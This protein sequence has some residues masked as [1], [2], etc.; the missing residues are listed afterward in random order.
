MSFFSYLFWC[1][2]TILRSVACNETLYIFIFRFDGFKYSSKVNC[3]VNSCVITYEALL[4]EVY[5]LIL[6][7]RKTAECSYNGLLN[8]DLAASIMEHEC[9]VTKWR[10][11]VRRFLFSAPAFKIVNIYQDVCPFRSIV[12][13]S[14][15]PRSTVTPETLSCLHRTRLLW[16][17]ICYVTS[18]LFRFCAG[19]RGRLQCCRFSLNCYMYLLV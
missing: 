13:C 11:A 5:A 18:G 12:L 10:T 4:P 14:H 6:L 8:D 19:P 9:L 15:P 2:E 17:W 1:P 16:D 7:N 3:S